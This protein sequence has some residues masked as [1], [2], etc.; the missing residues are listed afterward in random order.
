METIISYSRIPSLVKAQKKYQL[1][2]S[3]K[4]NDIAK[5]WYNKNKDNE[6]FKEKRRQQ[7]LKNKEKIKLL[8]E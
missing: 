7:Y 5:N 3:V 2:N 6:E 8:K 1:L 4:V